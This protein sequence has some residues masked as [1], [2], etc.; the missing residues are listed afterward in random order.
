[1]AVSFA[2]GTITLANWGFGAGDIAVIA[3]AGRA[4]GNWLMAQRRD[5][6]LLDFFAVQPEDIL[7]RKGL[8]DVVAL[9]KRWDQKLVLL[10]NGRRHTITQPGGAVVEN[11][12]GFTWFMSLVVAKL[13]CTFASRVVR[14]V[15]S[16]FLAEL[17]LDKTVGGADYL[18]QEAPQH[19][20][21]W[22]S[23]ACVRSISQVAQFAWHRLARERAHLPGNIPEADSAEI[24][25]FL[26]W[27][28]AGK[29][30]KFVTF[31]TD[32]TSFARVLAELG[33]ELLTSAATPGS[34][35][36][37]RLVVVLST[38]IV[39]PAITYPAI[40]EKRRGMR[41]PLN[42]LEECISLWPG[43]SNIRNK[44]RCIFRDG[45]QAAS[46]VRLA[47]GRG[48]LFLDW[49]E[50]EARDVYYTI[51]TPAK[52]NPGRVKDPGHF[53]TLYLVLLAPTLQAAHAARKLTASWPSRAKEI[54]GTWLREMPLSNDNDNDIEHFDTASLAAITELE[55]FVLGYYYAV[56]APLVDTSQNA[57]QEAY[58]S[59]G[60]NDTQILKVAKRFTLSADPDHGGRYPR[61]QVLKLLGYFYAGADYTEQLL[62]LREGTVG[63]LG[64]LNLLTGS[65]MGG[66]DTPDRVE[67]FWLLDID[68]TCI[69]SNSHGIV[70]CGRQKNCLRKTP[71]SC[72]PTS[73]NLAEKN[74][75]DADFT[76]HIE[77]DWEYDVQQVLV[78]YRHHG[79][80][81]HR[82]SPVDN[83]ILVLNSWISPI[84]SSQGEES[85]DTLQLAL[86]VG[87]KEF[88]GGNVIRIGDLTSTQ[89]H[90]RLQS[91]QPNSVLDSPLVILT[92]SA[93]KARACIVGMYRGSGSVALRSNS[94]Q[95]AAEDGAIVAIV[96]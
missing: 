45:M 32:V 88:Y 78:A 47:V 54:I 68:P 62:P 41:I 43:N 49:S 44:Y 26:I 93:P 39:P 17:V 48:N 23:N 89:V 10:K 86:S 57:L 5:R 9:H 16:Q 75:P 12:D 3:G 50:E 80:I 85:T 24:L 46:G 82:L 2:S 71:E 69:P 21:G 35:D 67:K 91:I 30:N 13:D 15:V 94:L 90:A 66:A 19:I 77:P 40:R 70:S 36:E 61:H 76:S 8:M 38:L 60:W 53:E 20:Q 11:M 79:R 55:I 59:W 6:A 83:D 37:N 84:E 74:T 58:G 95:K 4:V 18:M 31:S 92:G 65:V 7:Q 25:R 27:I 52:P 1:M 34:Y 28:A 72:Q 64:K 56:L 14:A 51:E 29:N 96:V 22:R 81:V 73:I 63:V 33:L 42:D 87:L